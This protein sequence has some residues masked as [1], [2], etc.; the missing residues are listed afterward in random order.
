VADQ[1]GEVTGERLPDVTPDARATNI[2]TTVAYIIKRSQIAQLR[3]SL[4]TH[5][6]PVLRFNLAICTERK[7]MAIWVR[8]Q[9][10][11]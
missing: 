7:G 1:S 4:L 6:N 10:L 2:V 3:A 9:V 8:L 5:F 11:R